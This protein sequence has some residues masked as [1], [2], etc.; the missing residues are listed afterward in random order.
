MNYRK[1]LLGDCRLDLVLQREEPVRGVRERGHAT[2]QD[3]VEPS[4]HID[5]VGGPDR[6]HV[7]RC[8]HVGQSR[9]RRIDKGRGYFPVPVGGPLTSGPAVFLLR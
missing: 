5:L 1:Q 2:R 4:L 9:R 7:A 3:L 6:L 8:R